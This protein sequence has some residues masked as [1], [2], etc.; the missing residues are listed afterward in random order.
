MCVACG[1]GCSMWKSEEDNRYLRLEQ[2]HPKM[3][4]YVIETLG[5]GEVLDYMNIPYSKNKLDKEKQKLGNVEVEQF[6]W[7]I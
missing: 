2:T 3:H 4:K 7:I 1:F 6:K 5:F